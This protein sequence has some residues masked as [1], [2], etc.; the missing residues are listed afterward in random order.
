MR[1]MLVC[2][3]LIAGCVSEETKQLAQGIHR[4]QAKQAVIVK[5]LADFAKEKGAL[6]E[7][8]HAKVVSGQEALSESTRS[9]FEILG[10]PK[11]PVEVD[12]W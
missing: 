2:L 3:V 9:L 12:S 6:G 10:E 1:V 5:E 8:A 11:T 7:A 4:Y